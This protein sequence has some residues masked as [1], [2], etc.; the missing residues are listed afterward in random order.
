MALSFIDREVSFVYL[1][2]GERSGE[3]RIHSQAR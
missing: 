2:G 3:H 1:Q